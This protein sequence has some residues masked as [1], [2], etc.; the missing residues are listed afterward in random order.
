MVFVNQSVKLPPWRYVQNQMSWW[1]N[2]MEHF[3][4]LL[5]LCGR[6]SSVTGDFPSESSVTRDLIFSLIRAWTSGWENN[7]DAGDLKR[8]WPHYDITV[9]NFIMHLVQ[10]SFV[11]LIYR[12]ESIAQCLFV[13]VSSIIF[14]TKISSDSDEV[15]AEI[16]RWLIRDRSPV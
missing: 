6:N 9:M 8:H 2:Q 14:G 1:R 15:V 13:I 7:R 16:M 5:A 4:R 10:F 11:Q 12:L 3:C